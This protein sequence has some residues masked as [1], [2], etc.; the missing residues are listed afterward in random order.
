MLAIH[1]DAQEKAYDEIARA[2]D[3]NV[4]YYDWDAISNLKYVDCILKETIRLYPLGSVVSRMASADIKLETHTIP[5]GSMIM[6]FVRKMQRNPLYWGPY[7]NQFDPDRFLEGSDNNRHPYAFVGFSGGVR[8]VSMRFGF[9]C[10]WRHGKFFAL[11]Q[12]LHWTQV[13]NDCDENPNVLFVDTF[14]VHHRCK[15]GRNSH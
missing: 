5:K 1:Q 3:P 2:C 6:L 7:A 11:N 8:F 15:N 12:E 14:Q 13:R 10:L 4:N 9:A